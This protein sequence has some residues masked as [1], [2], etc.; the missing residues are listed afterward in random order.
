MSQLD[1]PTLAESDDRVKRYQIAC[2][3]QD[4]AK[5]SAGKAYLDEAIKDMHKAYRAFEEIDPHDYRAIMELQ[6]RIKA[7][8]KTMDF[9]NVIVTD[10]DNAYQQLKQEEDLDET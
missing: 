10:G 8:R 6:I 7:T 3:V 2:A 1:L 5:S 9:I 4:A